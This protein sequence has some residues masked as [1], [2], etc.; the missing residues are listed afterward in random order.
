[1][2]S[3]VTRLFRVHSLKTPPCMRASFTA[4]LVTQGFTFWC[5]FYTLSGDCFRVPGDP[6]IIAVRFAV[7]DITI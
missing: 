3:A 7:P 4:A 5:R 6:T 1:M 2:A